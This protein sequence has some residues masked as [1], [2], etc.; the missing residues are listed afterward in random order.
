[1]AKTLQLTQ[2]ELQ[3]LIIE[4]Y[5][6][7]IDKNFVL[8]NIN[9]AKRNYEKTGVVEQA[10]IDDG[11][12]FLDQNQSIEANMK[13]VGRLQK[14]MEAAVEE[15]KRKY[16]K[17]TKAVESGD[18]AWYMDKHIWADIIAS[19]LYICLLYTSPSPRDG[20]LSRMPSSA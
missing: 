9:K 10:F 13:E 6:E 2:K 15:A 12:M 5:K 8:N 3:Q 20:L 11:M 18:K 16:P 17:G 7:L 4:T 19:I 14:N 1:M